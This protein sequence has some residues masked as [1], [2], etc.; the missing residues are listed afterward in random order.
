MN[1]VIGNRNEELGNEV[2]KIIKSNGGD[3]RFLKT[4]VSIENDVK[5]L[6]EFALKEFGEF[7]YAFNN[8]GL[9]GDVEPISVQDPKDSGYIVDVNIKGVIYCLHYQIKEMLKYASQNNPCSIVNNSSILSHAGYP[10]LRF[11]VLQNMLLQDL[12]RVLLPNVQNH[13]FE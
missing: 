13:I 8:S 7:N 5:N 1:V 10:A 4:D 2:V 11:T 3:A 6:T 12:P 9:L